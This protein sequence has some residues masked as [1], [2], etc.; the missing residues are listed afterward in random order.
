MLLTPTPTS[1]RSDPTSVGMVRRLLVTRAEARA[2]TRRHG[3]AHHPVRRSD[4]GSVHRED[5]HQTAAPNR[6]GR[7]AHPSTFVS[8]A[9]EATAVVTC[10]SRCRWSRSPKRPGPCRQRAPLHRVDFRGLSKAR[11]PY[12]TCA[13]LP[14]LAGRASP[15]LMPLQGVP[16]QT[17][18]RASS[19]R[20]VTA[21][22]RARTRPGSACRSPSGSLTGPCG[23]RD[24]LPTPSNSRGLSHTAARGHPCTG[25]PECK[26]TAKWSVLFRGRPTL[27]G[28]VPS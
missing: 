2:A 9:A 20:A 19:P 14:A 21:P 26:R 11:S 13:V 1:R 18:W 8:P 7:S 25:S 23:L 17:R 15:G 22:L 3:G 4:A 27:M 12:P 16:S 5:E 24:A 10:P 28:F 6:R